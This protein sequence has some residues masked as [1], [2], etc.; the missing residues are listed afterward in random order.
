M[1]LMSYTQLID[2]VESGVISLND[3]DQINGASIDLTLGNEILVEQNSD[4]IISLKDRTPLPMSR[5][6]IT[7]GQIGRAHV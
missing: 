3:Y 7:D 2:L 1:S 5:I 4:K 6:D